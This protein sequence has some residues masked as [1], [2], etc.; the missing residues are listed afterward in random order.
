MQEENKI[1]D[2]EVIPESVTATDVEISNSEVTATESQPETVETTENIC[3]SCAGK[4]R[5]SDTE[6]CSI[7]NGTGK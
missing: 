1:I 5:L 7:C 3:V 6:I 2:V 4:G